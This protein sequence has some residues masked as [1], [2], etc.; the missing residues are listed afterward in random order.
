MTLGALMAG[1]LCLRADVPPPVIQ[2]FQTSADGSVLLR[3]NA[4][5]EAAYRVLT[6]TDLSG[7]W[8]PVD[9]LVARTNSVT[10]EA[11]GL[12]GAA[13][14]YYKLSTDAIS[15]AIVEPS[16]LVMGA[17]VEVYIVGQGF[18][19][20]DVLRL[21]GP[22]G[23]MILSNRIVVSSTLMRVTLGPTFAGVKPGDSLRLEVTSGSSGQTASS[24]GARIEVSASTGGFDNATLLEPPQEPPAS[25]S[26]EIQEGKKGLNAVNVKLAR[27]AA[28]GGHG[29]EAGISRGTTST[30]A[31]GSSSGDVQLQEA[32][33]VIPGRGLDFIWARTYRSRPVQG[34]ITAPRAVA[35][36]NVTTAGLDA[37]VIGMSP[38][39]WRE[40]DEALHR[41]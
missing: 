41:A 40:I 7:E 36:K 15:I 5:P 26:F 8:T 11:N 23:T 25:P 24:K 3:W 19:A 30:K 21:I 31:G 29:G 13:A 39:I 27:T 28:G 17:V 2:Q 1:V 32:D 37:N 34:F 16:I 38:A 33:M 12:G 9:Y 18:G 20:D 22:G 4:T 6:A 10:W 14:R 35:D